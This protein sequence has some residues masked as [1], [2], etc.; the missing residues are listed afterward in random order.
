M[1]AIVAADWQLGVSPVGG[2]FTAV[3]WLVAVPAGY[4]I[5]A[6]AVSWFGLNGAG[7]REKS[8]PVDPWA[9]ARRHR[10]R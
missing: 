5:W 6:L 4:L 7:E 8:Q 2:F 9:A 3:G 10:R 1:V